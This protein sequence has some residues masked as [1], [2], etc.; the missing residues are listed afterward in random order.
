M[1]LSSSIETSNI[2]HKN[3]ILASILDIRG[4]FMEATERGLWPNGT[5]NALRSQKETPNRIFPNVF[6]NEKL[7][8]SMQKSLW[9][10]QEGASS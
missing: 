6:G 4:R 8:D 10:V 5:M 7:P 1:K 9:H 3:N 2:S